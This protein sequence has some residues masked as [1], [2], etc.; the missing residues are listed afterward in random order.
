MVRK[1]ALTGIGKFCSL[2]LLLGLLFVLPASTRLVAAAEEL[3]PQPPHTFFGTVRLD[4]APVADGT[5][6]QVQVSHSV[7]ESHT[8]TTAVFSSGGQNSLYRIRIPADNPNTS[9][10]DGGQPGDTILFQLGEATVAAS[11]PF[12]WGESTRQV[13]SFTSPTPT[14][15]STATPSSTVIPGHTATA[16]ATATTPAP[17]TTPSHTPS[18][19][20]TAM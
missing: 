13:L 2:V 16:T 6:I 19:T 12:N 8:L 4:G 17:T 3:P 15:S 14:P 11:T 5:N 1:D 18:A 10:Y 9:A 7:T 20:L